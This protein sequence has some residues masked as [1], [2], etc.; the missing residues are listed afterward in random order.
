[1]VFYYKLIVPSIIGH[2]PPLPLPSDQNKQG[3]PAKST[4]TSLKRS[5]SNMSSSSAA[6]SDKDRERKSDSPKESL[7]FE[8]TQV[9][10]EK[11]KVCKNPVNDLIIKFVLK[12]VKTFV[13]HSI[14]SLDV[15]I[16]AGIL[17]LLASCLIAFCYWGPVTCRHHHPKCI[18]K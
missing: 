2:E 6:S 10:R 12:P 14:Q 13:H 4:L 16:T 9:N 17:N 11:V 15:T 7:V 18:Y 3:V 8:R 5:A 1:M